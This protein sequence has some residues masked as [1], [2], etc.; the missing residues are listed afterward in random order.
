MLWENV[1]SSRDL[2]NFLAAGDKTAIGSEMWWKKWVQ[3]YLACVAFV[4]RQVGV[5]MEALEAS[6]YAENTIVIL[7]GDHG[8]HMGEK[9]NMH[10]TTIWEEVT[11]VP[12]VIAAP[13]I[14]KPGMQCSHPVSLI[15]IYPTL[16]DLAGLPEDPNKGGNGFEIDGHS[17]RPFLEDPASGSWDGR[18]VALNHLHGPEAVAVN[19]PSPISKNHHSVRSRR[20][21][22]TLTSNGQEEL[23]D[24][25][26]DPNEW[27]NLAD[28]RNDTL[29]VIKP[30]LKAELLYLT[31]R[32]P[33]PEVPD[34]IV[35][36]V[37]P[38]ASSHK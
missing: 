25:A 24:H 33:E 5:M 3:S 10:K 19:T 27:H 15:D 1:S 11:R 16:I 30:W 38:Q 29:D 14:S 31:G 35:D 12:L 18:P 32:G 7:T 23:Y 34:Q 37:P 36:V 6:E 17:I 21:R 28:T 8:Y 26:Q 22:Y 2:S 13:G 20:Y 4:D 9:D